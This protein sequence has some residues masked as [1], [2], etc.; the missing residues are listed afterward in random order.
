MISIYIQSIFNNLIKTTYFIIKIHII[1]NFK[2]NIFIN[3]NIMMSKEMLIN[4]NVK[5]F[6][7]IK[8]Q[9]L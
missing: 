9:R 1:N 5:I 4:L 6:I 8:C 3:I 7:L 2:I